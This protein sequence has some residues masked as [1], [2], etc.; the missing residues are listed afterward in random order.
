MR[1]DGIRCKRRMSRFFFQTAT[2]RSIVP[3]II[4]TATGSMW[5]QNDFRT[6]QYYESGPVLEV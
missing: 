4:V 5:K 3:D 1:C 2:L 6:I